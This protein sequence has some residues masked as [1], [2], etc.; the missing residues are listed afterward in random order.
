MNRRTMIAQGSAALLSACATGR[1]ARAP[2]ASTAPTGAFWTERLPRL[3]EY[4]AVPGVAVGMIE[5]G[6]VAWVRGFGV[7]TAGASDPVAE[8]TVFEAASLGKPVFAY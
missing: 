5:D 1:A 6:A 8:D 4:A 2:R 7:K 3:M